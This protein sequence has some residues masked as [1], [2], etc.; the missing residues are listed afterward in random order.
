MG[1]FKHKLFKRYL[2]SFKQKKRHFN[3]SHPEAS[4]NYKKNTPNSK[5]MSLKL[6][7]GEVM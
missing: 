4:I 6:L 1:K 5:E 2:T 7:A 3:L